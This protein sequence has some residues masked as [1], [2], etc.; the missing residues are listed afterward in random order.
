MSALTY[1]PSENGTTTITT[2]PGDTVYVLNSRTAT[3][4]HVLHRV[5]RIANGIA[6]T[7]CTIWA[8]GGTVMP[9]ETD[10]AVWCTHGCK[11]QVS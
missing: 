8:R 6:V 1:V 9:L 11:P 3:Y 2:Q 10:C 7:Y 5:D 4:K